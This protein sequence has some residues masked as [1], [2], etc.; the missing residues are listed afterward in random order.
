MTPYLQIVVS[1]VLGF[2][3]ILLISITDEKYLFDEFMVDNYGIRMLTGAYA[4]S[5]GK[6]VIQ[7]S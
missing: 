7:Y 4:A 5:A 2:I 6:T 1:S 3:G